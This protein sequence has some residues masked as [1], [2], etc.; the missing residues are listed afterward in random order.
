MDQGVTDSSVV[1]VKLRADENMVTYLRVKLLESSRKTEGK[2][3][4]MLMRGNSNS[5]NYDYEIRKEERT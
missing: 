1:A 3:M 4:N 5:R 2:G